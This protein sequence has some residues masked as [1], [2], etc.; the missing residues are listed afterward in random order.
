MAQHTAKP[1]TR[2]NKSRK[3]ATRPYVLVIDIGTFCDYRLMDTAV[4]ELRRTHK[5]V[6]ITN[7]DH[8][9]P[10]TDTRIDY[11]LPKVILDNPGDIATNLTGGLD[12]RVGYALTHPFVVTAS[13]VSLLHITKIVQYTV[14]HFK[15]VR[16][17]AHCGNVQHIIASGCYKTTPTSILYFAPGFLPNAEVPFVFHNELKTN[18]SFDIFNPSYAAFNQQSGEA[19]HT[20]MGKMISTEQYFNALFLH[21]DFSHLRQM[22]HLMCFSRP[23]VPHMRYTIPDLDIRNVGILPARLSTDPLEPALQ[24]WVEAHRGKIML[25]SFGSYLSHLMD[26]L[27]SFLATLASACCEND[28]YAIFH[29]E[30][31]ATAHFKS[32]RVKVYTKFVPYPSIVRHCRIV[33]FTG[34]VCLQNVCWM[35][36]CR[37]LFV[38][39]LPE[40]YFWAKLY[41]KHTHVDYVDHQNASESVV[42]QHKL[43]QALHIKRDFLK[44][45]C[46]SVSPTVSKRIAKITLE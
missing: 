31:A 34:S 6:Y 41:R 5:I 14:R 30:S 38:P 17:L 37:M 42:F 9:L 44:R 27:P 24:L 45:V 29:D 18:P 12:V 2:R 4:Q 26:T 7:P 11:T 16:I 36:A 15:P 21:L 33:C 3:P 46:E 28:M 40:Q 32:A 19:Y 8:A 10:A 22:K 23:L 20:Q 25:V 1:A 35:Q 39:Y 13:L 43:F